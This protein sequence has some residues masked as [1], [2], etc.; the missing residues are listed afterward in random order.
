MYLIQ[1]RTFLDVAAREGW[2]PVSMQRLI[3]SEDIPRPVEPAPRYI[4]EDI[5]QQLNRHLDNLPSDTQRMVLILQECG[6]RIS[7]LCVLPRDCII[8]DTGGDAFL[9]YYQGKMKKEHTI[10]VTPEVVAIIRAQ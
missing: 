7:E 8:H 2:A 1:L 5:V 6:M 4:P 9:R 3:Y 10:P